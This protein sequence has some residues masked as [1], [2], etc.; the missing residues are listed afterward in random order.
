MEYTDS[1]NNF[2]VKPPKFSWL[3]FSY[4]E[5][6]TNQSLK[7]KQQPNSEK[8][9]VNKIFYKSSGDGEEVTD[10]RSQSFIELTKLLTD[11]CQYGLLDE[12]AG[13]PEERE[14]Q[15]RQK[16][17]KK[18]KAEE[19]RREREIAEFEDKIRKEYVVLDEI[20][21][22]NIDND[23]N[24]PEKIDEEDNKEKGENVEN[25]ERKKEQLIQS[26]SLE[27]IDTDKLNKKNISQMQNSA[28]VKSNKEQNL[29]EFGLDEASVNNLNRRNSYDQYVI[30]FNKP[31]PDVPSKITSFRPVSNVAILS[32]N[33]ITSI[34][35]KQPK[36]K[37]NDSKFLK[38]FLKGELSKDD[39]KNQEEEEEEE[40]VSP[41]YSN[42]IEKFKTHE[43]CEDLDVLLE[44]INIKCSTSVEFIRT[45]SLESLESVDFGNKNT[46][47]SNDNNDSWISNISKSL[48]SWVNQK[49]EP[50][51]ELFTR[52]DKD[53]N[54]QLMSPK[55]IMNIYNV[56]Y[57]QALSIHDYVKRS[58]PKFPKNITSFTKYV[59]KINS[60][61]ADSKE[62]RTLELIYKNHNIE[63]II[64]GE[65]ALD[66]QTQLPN[67]LRAK[68]K[69]TMQYSLSASSKNKEQPA[70]NLGDLIE[71]SRNHGSCLLIIQD[72]NNYK[73]GI[74]L[75]EELRNSNTSYGSNDWF[76]WKYQNSKL[77][78][79]RPNINEKT[80][81]IFSNNDVLSVGGNNDGDYALY[82][83]KYLRNGHSYL[84]K[85]L[86]NKNLASFT[87]FYVSELELWTFD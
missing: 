4:Y 2:I 32:N 72:D 26:S 55:S 69:W 63:P 10:S 76:L 46:N 50:N 25:D 47:Q 21:L 51:Y 77:E 80:N 53:G 37:D 45:S 6:F 70:Q 75:N 3:N 49:Y 28:P 16:E 8:N 5:E 1:Y 79:F 65:L 17:I 20:P 41:N 48:Q 27:K 43:S 11:D 19:E 39:L 84:N 85:N 87:N 73:F 82:I 35:I 33:Y 60:R 86:K 44:N 34:E 61:N 68:D 23:T 29:K 38:A 42:H 62:R 81:L 66:I 14:E 36:N 78:V 52:T 15:K 24:N 83:D 13:T 74:F 58:I 9:G 67:N 7:S 56:D 57:N 59:E 64:T 31:L 30:Q 22:D 54:L 71:A 40:E 18:Q 12:Y